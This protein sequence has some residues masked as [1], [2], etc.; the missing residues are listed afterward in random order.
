MM[1]LV[2]NRLAQSWLLK[3]SIDALRQ[4]IMHA[5]IDQPL[6]FAKRFEMAST[7]TL[8]VAA[9]FA[10]VLASTVANQVS[11]PPLIDM[12]LFAALVITSISFSRIVFAAIAAAGLLVFP[13]AFHT[14]L[15][16][17]SQRVSELTSAL[18]ISELALLLFLICLTVLF[19]SAAFALHKKIEVNND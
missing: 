16:S 12:L 9:I 11:R 6:K 19:N 4:S 17:A 13:P 7:L 2:M 5:S 18:P 15:P 3:S 14:I 1:R 8:A 10:A